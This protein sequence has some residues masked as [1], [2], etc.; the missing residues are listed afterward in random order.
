MQDLLVADTVGLQR[1]LL[2]Q[3]GVT[4]LGLWLLAASGTKYYATSSM[5]AIAVVLSVPIMIGVFRTRRVSMSCTETRLIVRNRWRSLDVRWEE[6]TGLGWIVVPTPNMRTSE[7][8]VPFAT[9]SGSSLPFLIWVSDIT[10]A[11]AQAVPPETLR[12]EFGG[13]AQTRGLRYWSRV[14]NWP[15]AAVSAAWLSA[16]IAVAIVSAFAENRFL[17]Q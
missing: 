12:H 2:L 4:L 10:L 5:I 15:V 14:P 11:R 7:M 9:T 16:I 3:S 17:G 6:L 8:L 1:T 13:Y